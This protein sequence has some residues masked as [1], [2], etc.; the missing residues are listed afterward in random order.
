MVIKL[1]IAQL[2]IS[3]DYYFHLIIWAQP[4]GKD[5]FK[6]EMNYFCAVLYAYCFCHP[7]AQ[8]NGNHIIK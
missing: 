3:P 4:G 8:P 5:G 6:M 2:F 7:L 1:L